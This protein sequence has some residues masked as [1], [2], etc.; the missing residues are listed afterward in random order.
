MIVAISSKVCN[1]ENFTFV[2][3][4]GL[5]FKVSKPE[6]LNYKQIYSLTLSM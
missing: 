1:L 2:F 6:T 4:S 3:V 5:Q